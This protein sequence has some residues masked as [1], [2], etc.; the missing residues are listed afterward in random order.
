[1][2]A[3]PTMD[4]EDLVRLCQTLNPEN[5]AGRLNVIVRMGAGKVGDGLPALIKAVQREGLNVV[6]S[7]DPMHGNT[8]KSSNNY[9]T[10]PVDAILTPGITIFVSDQLDDHIVAYDTLG[11][12]LGIWVG[13]IP[14]TLDNMRGIKLAPDLNSLL[15]TV[16]SGGNQDAI[17]QFDPSGNYLGNFITPNAT[18]MDGPW[19]IVFRTSDVLVSAS[20]SNN[21]ARYDL[22]G[23]YLDNFVSIT[24]PEQ[25][26]ELASGNIIAA[27]FSG[28][29]GLYIYDSNGTQLNYFGAVTGLRGCYQLLN[30]NYLVTSGTGVHEI[31]GT[32]GALVRTVISGV[33]GRFV[34]P[35]DMAAVPVELTSFTANVIDGEV[36]LIWS[37]ATETNNSGFQVER[38]TNNENYEQVAFVP[39]FGT[40]TEPKNYSYSDN[41]V[42]NGTYYYRLKQIDFDGSF[43]YS[44][45]VEINIGLPHEFALQQNYPNPFNPTTRIN[46]SVPAD[47]FVNISVYNVLGE[48][49]TEIV[50]SIQKAGSY[51]ATFNATDFVSGMYIYR[52][53]SGDFVSIKKMMILK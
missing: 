3:G 1:M 25:I 34:E 45:V 4:P 8:I 49:V 31:D 44:E 35:F 18:V 10:R 7:C 14:D 52:M 17:A 24:F 15:L 16:A 50:N 5:E 30:G 9:K 41:S 19:E 33:S 51:E 20:T 12:L 11:G 6:W 43:T 27:G 13:G 26:R 46:Y 2:K 53:E 28:S 23:T 42:S 36:V 29:S 21:I 48:K 39:G 37:T 40:T 38:S 32:T 22:S 47:G